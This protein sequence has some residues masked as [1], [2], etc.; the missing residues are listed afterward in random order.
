MNL[1]DYEAKRQELDAQM[2]KMNEMESEKKMEL[3]I[4]LQKELKS[5]ASK[6]GQLKKQRQELEKNYQKDKSWWHMKFKDE[7]Q[8]IQ[9][10]MHILRL[11]YLTVNNI[12]CKETQQ[13]KAKVGDYG[14]NETNG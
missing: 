2:E 1:S 10:K 11:E 9:A 7:K 3:S 8:Q 13:N 4:K 5:I 12:E 6:I 14:E